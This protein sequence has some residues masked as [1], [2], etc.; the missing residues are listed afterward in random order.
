MP[1]LPVA[2]FR[3]VSRI[4]PAASSP[5]TFAAPPHRTAIEQPRRLGRRPHGDFTHMSSNVRTLDRARLS[6][7]E[8]VRPERADV[9]AAI[10]TIIRWSGDDPGRDG[11][12]ETPARV[13]RAFEEYFAGY[14]QDPA[15]I[16]Q[17]TFE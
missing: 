11:L 15:E 13:A 3:P 16:L 17:K 8:G 9:E 7:A 2:C 5:G 12:I 14:A 10:R 1:H 6:P 4:D